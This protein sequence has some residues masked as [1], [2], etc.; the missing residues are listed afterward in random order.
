MYNNDA[1]NLMPAEEIADRPTTPIA[2]GPSIAGPTDSLADLTD[3]QILQQYEMRIEFLDRGAIV[4][5]GCKAIA[6]EKA[7]DAITSIDAYV[8]DPKGVGKEWRKQFNMV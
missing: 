4:R 6:F 5:I 3:Q 7:Q 8:K 1:M 2:L